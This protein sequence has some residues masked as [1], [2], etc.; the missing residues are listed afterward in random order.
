MPMRRPILDEGAYTCPDTCP[1][2]NVITTSNR[3]DTSPI[4][5]DIFLTASA[6]AERTSSVEPAGEAER[7]TATKP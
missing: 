1:N 4:R 6:L 2:L 3:L 5:V 7:A